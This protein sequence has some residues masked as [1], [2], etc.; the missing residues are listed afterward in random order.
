M[1]QPLAVYL[2]I[3]DKRTFAGAIEWPGWS[4]SGRGEEEALAALL[5]YAPRY[6]AVVGAAGLS[7]PA[8][9]DVEVVERLKGGSG[10]DFGVPS[11]AP[12]ADDRPMS[13]AAL[14]RQSRLLAASWQA[15]DIAWQEATDAHVKLRLGPRGGGRDLP[16]MQM[17]VLEAEEAYLGQLGSRWPRMPGATPAERMAVVRET[18][19]EALAARARGK[20]LADPRQTK[21]PWSPR[22]FVRR[23]AWHVLDHA[24]EIEDRAS[25]G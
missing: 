15:F 21:R 17:H 16:K 1:T 24:W 14:D 5:A 6:G 4:R 2:E 19:L 20:P 9:K 3:G 11:V 25:D 22:Y 8:A 18:V 13:A 10:T 7:A 23:S 12:E